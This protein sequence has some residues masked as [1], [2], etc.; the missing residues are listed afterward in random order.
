MLT[1]TFEVPRS[2][3]ETWSFV[4]EDYFANHIRWDAGLQRLEQLDDGR[5][6]SGLRGRE[7]RS[8][9]G[10]QVSEFEVTVVEPTKRLAMRDDPGLWALERTYVFEPTECGTSVTFR[11][12]M[13]PK[14]LWFKLLFPIVSRLVIYRQVRANMERLRDLL[15]EDR[16]HLDQMSSR[17]DQEGFSS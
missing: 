16:I 2:V 15:T 3:E 14:R 10:E 1:V 17:I 7:I 4:A 9:G 12:D 11:F 6:R 5:I 8:L 13:G